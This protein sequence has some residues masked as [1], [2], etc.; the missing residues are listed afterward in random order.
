MTQPLSRMNPRLPALV[1]L[2]LLCCALAGA[3]QAAILELTGPQGATVMVNGRLRG[4]FPLDHPL[5]LGPGDHTV[6]CTLAGHKDYRTTVHLADESDWQRLHVRMTPLSKKTAVLSN[7]VLAGLG[8]HYSEN[9]TRG[10]I[11]NLAEAGGLLTAVVGEAGRVNERKDY[12]LLKARYDT[13]I[14]P[15]DIA[16]YKEKSSQAYQ[17]MTDKEDMRNMGLMVAGG[18][19]LL[20]MIDAWITFPGFE[21]GPGTGVV[22]PGQ[23]EQAGTS[24]TGTFDLSTVHAGVKLS[25]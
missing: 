21:A 2:A 17:N 3:A 20:S 22:H 11:Y 9:H 15:E 13:A 12:L 16:Y 1:G 8:Q 10:W 24:K 14:N 6:Q 23:Y 5:D 25:F 19:V 18:A 4:Q 7:I